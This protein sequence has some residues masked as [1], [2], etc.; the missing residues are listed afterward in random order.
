MQKLLVSIVSVLTVTSVVLCAIVLIYLTVGAGE[1]FRESLSF[2]VVVLVASIPMVRGAGAVCRSI[3]FF[4]FCASIEFLIFIN[5]N[6]THTL[7]A[8]AGRRS[9]L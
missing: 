8:R 6:K 9:R 7:F 5:N 3:V 4:L 1:S 2:V